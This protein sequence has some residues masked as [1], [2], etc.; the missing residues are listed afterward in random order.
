MTNR[1]LPF[2][3]IVIPVRNGERTVEPCLEA[4]LSLDY[5]GELEIKVVDNGS[6]D[7]TVARVA[8]LGVPLVHEPSQ[9]RGIAR[10]TGIRKTKGEIVAFIDSDCIAEP[11]WL[12][13]LVRPY[14]DPDVVG[15]G[16]EIHAATPFT[17]VQKYLERR[18]SCW[19]QYCV[20]GGRRKLSGF[21]ITANAS[22][23][24]WVL[25]L[26]GGFDPHF[27]TAEDVD[28]GHRVRN[29]GYKLAYAGG[30]IVHHHLRETTRELFWQRY[31]Y[32]YGRVLMRRRHN[33]HRGYSLPKRREVARSTFTASLLTARSLHA[34]D[35]AG[36][37]SYARCEAVERIAL[38]LGATHAAVARHVP[39]LALLA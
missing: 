7:S 9:G 2:V 31:S 15:V 34:P 37:A 22:Y 16:G 13:E 17:G 6:T 1:A 23:R 5:E 28:L 27:V 4:L 8:S 18:E 10:N 19:Q 11:S 12:T 3:S 30:A 33:L 25:D 21:L 32:G 24:R 35:V 38:R 36:D 20:Q 39:Q 14:D 26:V 29:T